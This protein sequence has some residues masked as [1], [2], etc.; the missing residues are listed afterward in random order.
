MNHTRRSWT[1][2]LL[3]AWSTLVFWG[4][5]VRAA[6]GSQPMCSGV[7]S[8]RSGKG[9]PEL[10]VEVVGPDGQ[11]SGSKTDPNGAYEF[12]VPKSGPYGIVFHEPRTKTRLHQI[13][14]LT[15]QTKQTLSVTLDL[16]LTDVRSAYAAAQAVEVWAALAISQPNVEAWRKMVEAQDFRALAPT[17][18]RVPQEISGPKVNSRQRDLIRLKVEFAAKLLALASR[19]EP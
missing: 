17:L 4:R 6:Q 1:R 16:A 7:V 13:E 3:A 19:D 5:A 2:V 15:P 10:V 12:P 18:Q 9:I 11:V 14:L 8:D